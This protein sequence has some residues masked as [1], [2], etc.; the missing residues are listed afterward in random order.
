M[1]WKG[2][3]VL[4]VTESAQRREHNM[5]AQQSR[6]LADGS[7]GTFNYRRRAEIALTA[8]SMGRWELGM[9]FHPDLP[10]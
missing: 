1:R 3:L 5:N 9:G 8:L 10:T 7:R 2:G 6:F 4:A